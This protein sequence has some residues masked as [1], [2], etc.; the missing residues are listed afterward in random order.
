MKITRNIDENNKCKELLERREDIS[1]KWTRNII[2]QYSD[3]RDG[4]L[5]KLD[6]RYGRLF[7]KKPI[8]HGLFV[9]ICGVITPQVFEVFAQP[10]TVMESLKNKYPYRE[11]IEKNYY[12]H[13][14]LTSSLY[15]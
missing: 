9:I 4:V 7:K 5:Y 3:S 10:S 2:H 15:R 6:Y 13:L 11:K 8:T 12:R 14:Y 1:K